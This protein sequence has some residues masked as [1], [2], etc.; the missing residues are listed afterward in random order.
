MNVDSLKDFEYFT[1]VQMGEKDPPYGAPRDH[2]LTF[3]G[4][5]LELTFTLPMKEPVKPDAVHGYRDLLVEV[6]DPTFFVDLTFP[7]LA[8][9]GLAGGSG[10]CDASLEPRKELDI[11]TSQLLAQVGPNEDIPEEIAPAA[12]DL[13]NTIRVACKTT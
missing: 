1:Y 12:G 9:A 10:K 2:F 5:L 6:F 3:D 13:S 11:F 7:T 8:A 4:E